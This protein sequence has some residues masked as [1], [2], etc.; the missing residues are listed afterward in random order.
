MRG[1]T[2]ARLSAVTWT[3][4]V[5]HVRFPLGRATRRQTFVKG[6]DGVRA[7][8]SFQPQVRIRDFARTRRECNRPCARIEPLTEHGWRI[9]LRL[10][11]I[12]LDLFGRRP[13]FRCGVAD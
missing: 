12:F 2:D 7:V 9:S 5:E 11:A 1:D 10:A 8:G 13:D 3:L 6:D 4:A